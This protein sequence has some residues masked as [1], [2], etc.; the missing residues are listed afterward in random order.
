MS[1]R[2][3]LCPTSGLGTKRKINRGDECPKKIF[4]FLSVIDSVF[5]RNSW[6]T[7]R[8]YFQILVLN[9]AKSKSEKSSK[10]FRILVRKLTRNTTEIVEV[11]MAIS[12]HKNSRQKLTRN[13]GSTI[14]TFW[15]SSSQ[16]LCW[17]LI[18]NFSNNSSKITKIH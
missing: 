9:A 14:Q 6:R 2:I 3:L 7:H 12:H 11:T 13:L 16:E 4:E 10:L 18:R 15:N 17:V 1:L 5:V 8:N